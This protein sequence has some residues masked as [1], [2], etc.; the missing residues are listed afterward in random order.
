MYRRDTTYFPADEERRI[1]L[2]IFDMDGV[3][4]D[5]EPYHALSLIHIYGEP[6]RQ[7]VLTPGEFTAQEGKFFGGPAS[8][9]FERSE[10]DPTYLLEPKKIIGGY[11]G[12]G[13]LYLPFGKIVCDYKD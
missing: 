3:L 7:L 2:I 9:T 13:D 10:I 6:L 12:K 4:F 1:K 11:Y 5:S 8:V